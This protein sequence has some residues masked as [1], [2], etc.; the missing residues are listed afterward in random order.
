V[1]TNRDRLTFDAPAGTLTPDL[2]GLMKARKPELLAVVRG[3]YL[4]AALA[5][6]L[7]EPEPDRQN[8]LAEWFDEQA[9][10]GEYDGSMS[11]GEA[12]RSA[13]IAL[14]RAVEGGSV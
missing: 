2:R 13:Y 5:M 12:E 11:R 14:C 10:I 8:A 7:D 9:G 1:P 4:R 6:V 3:D